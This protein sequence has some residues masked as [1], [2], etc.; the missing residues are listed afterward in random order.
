MTEIELSPKEETK[1]S[2]VDFARSRRERFGIVPTLA[3]QP[4]MY[5]ALGGDT[6]NV[7]RSNPL[8]L[9]VFADA[10]PVRT[11]R[12]AARKSMATYD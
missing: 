11:I 4:R 3:S 12:L 10:L 9:L 8:S 1:I 6:L 5:P 7:I 2:G